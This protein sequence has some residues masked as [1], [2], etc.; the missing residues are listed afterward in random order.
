M[1]LYFVINCYC[2]LLIVIENLD[3]YMNELFNVMFGEILN[4]IR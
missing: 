1:Y 2:L 4:V 3:N